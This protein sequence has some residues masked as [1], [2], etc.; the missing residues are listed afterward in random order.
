MGSVL[1]L[2]SLYTPHKWARSPCAKCILID[3]VLCVGDGLP[4]CR[5]KAIFKCQEHHRGCRQLR[6]HL[7][8]RVRPCTVAAAAP[9][10]AALGSHVCELSPPS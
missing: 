7:C 2:P 9:H 8:W 5:T 6:P 3:V 1:S 4:P 10:E